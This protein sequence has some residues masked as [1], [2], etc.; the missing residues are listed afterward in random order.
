MLQR[1]HEEKGQH[2]DRKAGGALGRAFSGD[3]QHDRLCRRYVQQSLELET[4]Q[5]GRKQRTN[6]NARNNGRLSVKHTNV[7]SLRNPSV[8]PMAQKNSFYVGFDPSNFLCTIR[9][10]TSSQ[11]HRSGAQVRLTASRF[12]RSLVAF[13]WNE[14]A[15]MAAGNVNNPTKTMTKMDAHTARRREGRAVSEAKRPTMHDFHLL[16][17]AV[18]RGNTSPYPTVVSVITP[19][20]RA[21]AKLANPNVSLPSTKTIAPDISAA[22]IR[23]TAKAVKMS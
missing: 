18:V 17:P 11:Q 6:V 7:V 19:H 1:P 20:H 16:F 3:R 2:H 8:K 5:E 10:H 23:Q 12:S 9:L 4:E 21:S 22:A 14:E 15:T 13:C